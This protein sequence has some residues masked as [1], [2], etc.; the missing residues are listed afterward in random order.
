MANSILRSV[1]ASETPRVAV[2][3]PVPAPQT[4][5]TSRGRIVDM[6]GHVTPRPL[7]VRRPS[8]EGRQSPRRMLSQAHQY[9]HQPVMVA[10]RSVSIGAPAHLTP[11]TSVQVPMGSAS[12]PHLRSSACGDDGGGIRV[13]TSASGAASTPHASFTTLPASVATPR[14]LAPHIPGPI[15]NNGSWSSRVAYSVQ[16]PVGHHSIHSARLPQSLSSFGMGNSINNRGG[17]AADLRPLEQTAENGRKGFAFVRI[18]PPESSMGTLSP[19][20]SR[21]QSP[22][23]KQSEALPPRRSRI[24]DVEDDDNQDVYKIYQQIVGVGKDSISKFDLLSAMRRSPEVSHFLLPGVNVDIVLDDE[25]TFNAVDGTFESIAHGRDRIKF[26]QFAAYFRRNSEAPVLG[27]PDVNN[28]IRSIFDKIDVEKNGSVSK[29][30]FV[31]AVQSNPQVDEFILP[32]V[33]AS[34]LMTEQWSFDPVDAIFDAISG[35]ARRMSYADFETFFSKVERSKPRPRKGTDRSENRILM[36]GPGNEDEVTS[37]LKSN[38]EASRYQVRWLHELPF[39]DGPS[40]NLPEQLNDLRADIEQFNPDILI[41]VSKGGIYVVGLW[42]MGYWRG[43]TVLVNAHPSCKKLPEGMPIVVAHGANDEV[44]QRSRLELEDIIRTGTEN[45]CFLYYTLNR[46]PLPN[47]HFSCTG[48]SHSMESLLHHDCFPRLLDATIC[49][50]GPEMHMM[51]TWRDRLCEKRLDSEQWLGYSPFQLQKHWVSRSGT[52]K[53]RPSVAKGGLVLHDV[54]AGSLEFQHVESVFSNPSL[55]LPAYQRSSEVQLHGLKILRI[56]RVQNKSQVDLATKPYYDSLRRSLDEQDL[57]F[58]PG[59]HTCWAF[60]G[61]DSSAIESILSDPVSGFQPSAPGSSD[62]ALWGSGVYFARDAA[63]VASGSSCGP[64]GEDGARQMMLCLLS[65]GM[66]CLGDPRQR[67]VLPY[68]QKPHRYNSAVDSLSSPEIY[69]LQHPSAACP[70]YL[71]T[72][73]CASEG[74]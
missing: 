34:G 62:S 54:S 66:P 5:Q 30:E 28:D 16:V 71:I 7:S 61:A 73:S 37:R 36:I 27:I 9:Q 4:L 40:S 18:A 69:I 74:D 35:G 56:E 41:G 23:G 22:R 55:E 14:L 1:S 29:L 51:R 19:V 43:P 25:E 24:L 26:A 65:I 59:T 2:Y 50:D 46:G 10:T 32:G 12:R 38:I 53:R 70:A 57:A 13:V 52:R 11:T 20:H 42:Q 21:C 64:P 3:A 8:P 67:G 68:R 17:D 6:W 39:S 31:A 58:E 49:V 60:H 48:D 47:G 15:H 45:S 33:D 44:Y 72:F 63:H